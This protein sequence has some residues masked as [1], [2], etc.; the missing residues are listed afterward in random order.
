M[1]RG[2]AERQAEVG[3]ERQ[4]EGGAAQQEGGAE[5]VERNKGDENKDRQRGRF[6]HG[7]FVQT[8]KARVQEDSCPGRQRNKSGASAF[9]GR[10]VVS[11]SHVGVAHRNGWQQPLTF[12]LKPK[13]LQDVQGARVPGS[14]A[15]QPG[16]GGRAAPAQALA[17]THQPTGGSRIT[18]ARTAQTASPG[19]RPPRCG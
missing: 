18:A 17:A 7:K 9:A 6:L 15:R 11:S 12:N 16:G 10:F 13:L 5:T 4:A 1:G 14:G 3:A 2:G 19:V 8:G